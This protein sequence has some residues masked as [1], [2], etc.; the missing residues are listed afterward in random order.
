VVVKSPH[1][2][3]QLPQLDGLRGVAILLVLLL[4]HVGGSRLPVLGPAFR[5]GWIGVDLFFVL[6]GFLITRILVSSAGCSNYFS[7]FYARRA[8]R[9]W[10]VYTLALAFAFTVAP[11]LGPHLAFDFSAA[12]VLVHAFYVQNVAHAGQYGPWP[13]K[14]TWSLAI[15][16]QFYLLWPLA[17]WLLRDR[18]G[19]LRRAVAVVIAAVPLARLAAMGAG[20]TPLVVYTHTGFRLDALA[21]GC[22]CALTV[23]GGAPVHRGWARL[24]SAALVPG[25]ALAYGVLGGNALID[26]NAPVSWP[27][28]AALAAT[29]SLLAVGFGGV[30]ALLLEPSATARAAFT[31]A[32]LRLVGRVSYGL[33]VYHGITVH[34]DHGLYRPL[35]AQLLPAGAA[36]LARPAGLA[37][38]IATLGL[39]TWLSWTFMERPL[40]SLKDR[41]E[42]R[43]GPRAPVPVLG[44]S[45]P[46]S[47]E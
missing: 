11:R 17:V 33:Y 34:L 36:A 14:V 18:A 16:E 31:W 23:G 40:L 20:V 28:A 44:G 42:P 25:A 29:F 6:S 7:S 47:V 4:H 1:P 39:V 12:D 5:I 32:P 15:E 27:V 35:L 10:P 30:L 22:F 24:A 45:G 21:V 2:L 3:K 9:I 37:M 26:S 41:F 43:A 46:R 8:L 19:S 13:L 38:G